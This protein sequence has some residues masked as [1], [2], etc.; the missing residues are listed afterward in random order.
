MNAMI[1]V[2]RYHLVQPALSLR[3]RDA[4][5]DTAVDILCAAVAEGQL[6]VT[7]LD[8]RVGAALCARTICELAH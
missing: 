3:S 6:T 2:A 1:N 8:E 4:D 5:R 7:E